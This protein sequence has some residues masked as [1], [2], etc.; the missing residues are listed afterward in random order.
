[1]KRFWWPVMV[2][3]VGLTS[4]ACGGD[5]G[6][7]GTGIGDSA[8]TGAKGTLV[9]TEAWAR[10]S[11]TMAD[12]GAVYMTIENTGGS[13]DALVGA[14]VDPSVA[15][16]AEL[17]EVVTVDAGSSGMSGTTAGGDT[18]GDGTMQMQQVDRIDLPAGGSVDLEPGAYHVML[19]D[20]AAPLE[21]GTTIAITLDF[22]HASMFAVDAEV[23]VG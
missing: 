20:L 5:D 21:A 16:G 23:R 17:H 7:G 15:A 4:A 1:M 14:A 2:A 12:A 11:P 9:V 3:V 22:E 19:V 10:S 13:D 8:A 6:G 18:G